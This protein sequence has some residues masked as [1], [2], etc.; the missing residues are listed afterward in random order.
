MILVSFFLEDNVLSDEIKNAI[1]SNIKVTKI[2]RSAFFGT[3]GINN[4]GIF[5]IVPIAVEVELSFHHY[6]HVGY[7]KDYRNPTNAS[8]RLNTTCM[9]KCQRA[10]RAS[11][12]AK[13]EEI[14]LSYELC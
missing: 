13:R 11:C 12:S 1:F 3:P 14:D 8:L 10:E 5:V 6:S 7:N 9:C 2:E 4:H